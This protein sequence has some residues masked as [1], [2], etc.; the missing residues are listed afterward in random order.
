MTALPD[1]WAYATAS[2]PEL[3]GSN[4]TGN[5]ASNSQGGALVVSS[6]STSEISSGTFNS[7]VAARGAGIYVV[8]SSVTVADTNFTY[9]A[10]RSA[11][12]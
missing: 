4:F 11:G 9:N 10:A 5:S 8:N 2:V 1:L 6:N 7:N 12:Q 3:Q